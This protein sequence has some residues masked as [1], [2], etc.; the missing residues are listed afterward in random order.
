MYK[1]ML[2]VT[3]T[4][5]TAP[6]PM[7]GSIKLEGVRGEFT[8]GDLKTRPMKKFGNRL[9]YEKFGNLIEFCKENKIHVIGE[10]YK[11][12]LEF[13][14]I[15]SMCRANGKNI[16]NL[17]LH[18]FDV[19]DPK[20]PNLSFKYREN[21]YNEIVTDVNNP[22]IFPVKH[23]LFYDQDE[24]RRQYERAVLDGYE[25]FVLR[26]P[27]EPY[28]F[29][30]STKNEA[31]FLRMKPEETYDGVVL[32]IVE[33]MENLCESELNELGYLSKRQDKDLKAN[34]GMAAVAITKCEEFNE[35]IRVTLSRGL[36]DVDRTRIWNARDSYIGKHIRFIGIPVKGMLPRAPRFDA[37]RTDL[38]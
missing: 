14:Q 7:L 3:T 1:P 11:H 6:L 5:E 26:H 2:A 33:R 16:D 32:E 13:N 19:F 28:K 30:R 34:T 4:V 31:K 10:F 12:G 22:F 27:E 9:L 37:W 17:E 25:G 21:M 35:P 23:E 24:L 20:W 15:S 29:G 8:P 18:I 38:D 36:T